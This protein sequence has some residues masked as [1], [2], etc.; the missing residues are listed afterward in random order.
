MIAAAL[1]RIRLL[2]SGRKPPSGHQAAQPAF[3]S[4]A[5]RIRIT[6]QY[7]LDDVDLIVRT[8]STHDVVY[9]SP[10]DAFRMAA[11]QLP[12]WFRGGLDPHSQEYADQQYKLWSLVTRHERPY[13]P[14][15]DEKEAPLLDVDA[16]RR[17]AC[18]MR[19]D[20]EAVRLAADQIIATGM[21][22]KHS[23]VKP[24]ARALEYGAGFGQ[25]SLALAR[26]GVLVDTVDISQTFC[27]FVREQA[28]FFQASLTAFEGRFGWNPRGN[29]KYDLIFFYEAFHHCADFRSVVHDLK[30]HLAPDGRVLL[31][32][33]P[34]SRTEN[35]YL[36]Y[37]WGL[38]L[39]AEPIAQVRRFGWLELGFTEEF[40]IRLFTDAG[41]VAERVECAPS[42]NGSGYI[43]RH[44]GTKL[45]LSEQ[46]FPD[47]LSVGWNNPEQHGRWTKAEAQL[48]LDTTDNFRTLEIDA[49]NHHPFMQAVEFEY[50]SSVTTVRFRTGQRKTVVI[51]AARKAPRLTIR[52]QVHV[53]VQDYLFRSKD[54]R[55]LGILIRGVTYQQ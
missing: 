10:W 3:S 7:S 35:P 17:P 38:R 48:L 51:D 14:E 21:I 12:S 54:T 13:M 47:D 19:R 53:P 31:V 20:S 52:T 11:M 25:A 33:E 40:L 18:Y 16:I 32:G 55:Q 15:M 49:Q 6:G 42:V 37:P 2:R 1:R 24:G 26:L 41:F 36:P 5:E 4:D 27:R 30:R 22:L 39:D 44:R 43:F 28:D 34:I 46:W 29:Q 23:G 45:L 8:I 9:G 50:G